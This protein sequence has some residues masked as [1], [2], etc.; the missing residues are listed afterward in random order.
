MA[1]EKDKPKTNTLAQHLSEIQKSLKAPKG[2]YN[3]F[4]NY[5][6]RSCEDILEA[7]KEVLPDGLFVRVWDEIIQVGERYYVKAT[8]SISDGENEICSPAFAREPESKKG[9]DEAQLTGATSSYA[10]K[11]A[12]N[13]LFCIDD[14]KDP[15]AT[16]EHKTGKMNPIDKTGNKELDQWCKDS[17]DELAVDGRTTLESFDKKWDKIQ[18]SENYEKLTEEQQGIL[19]DQYDNSR[20]QIKTPQQIWLADAKKKIEDLKTPEEIIEWCRDN[21]GKDLSEKQ[22]EWFDGVV[23]AQTAKVSQAPMEQRN[24]V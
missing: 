1:T 3:K 18:Y 4:G 8:A 2:Q 16:N 24:G 17:I 5:N 14:T 10:R 13:A 7:L 23:K 15:D 6:Y 19:N 12:L 20:K 21:P 11:Y 9:M 22:V